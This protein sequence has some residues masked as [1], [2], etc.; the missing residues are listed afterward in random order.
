MTIRH[1]CF[2][3]ALLSGYAHAG[4]VIETINRDLGGTPKET[5]VTTSAQD[6]QLRIDAADR[7]GFSIFKDDALY[8][9]NAR[10]KTY[11]VMDRAALKQLADT[12]SPAMKLLAQMPPEQREQVERLLGKEAAALTRSATQEI[13]KT[14]RTGQAAGYDCTYVEIVQDAAVE[15]ELC[16]V[17]PGRLRGGD[18]L[19][20]AAQSLSAMLQDAF[21]DLDAPQLKQFIDQQTAMYGKVG[22]IPVLSRH[23]ADGKAVSETTL[24]SSR[25]ETIPASAFA[26]P[27]GYTRKDVLQGR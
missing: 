13:R 10:D 5:V 17:E 4:T 20:S 21:R 27:E 19:M 23:F 22:G 12:I 24:R 6:G 11:V 26:V 9:V 18:E 1:I 3:A 2:T 16:V 14:T 7:D 15:D 25:T 8:I